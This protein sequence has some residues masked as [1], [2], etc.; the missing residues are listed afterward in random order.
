M[1]E[2]SLISDMTPPLMGASRVIFPGVLPSSSSAADPKHTGFPSGAETAHTDGSLSTSPLPALYI[3]VYSV[4]G[5]SRYSL[6][7]EPLFPP[8]QFWMNYAHPPRNYTPLLKKSF[9]C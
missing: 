8:S 3:L 7:E 2:V 1:S 6:S 5:L 4:P 9:L